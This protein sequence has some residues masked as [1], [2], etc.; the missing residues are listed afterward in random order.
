MSSGIG[1]VIDWSLS[2]VIIAR[3]GWH[4][5]FYMVA[6]ALGLFSVAWYFTVFDSPSK[7]PRIS[8]TERTYILNS[9]NALGAKEKV[10]LHEI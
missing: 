9:I 3:L 10:K 4:F 2:G 8:K 7:H 1:T 6:I 5:A